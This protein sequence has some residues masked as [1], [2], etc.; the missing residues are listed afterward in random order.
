[1]SDAAVRGTKATGAEGAPATSWQSSLTVS[2]VIPAYTMKRWELL[3]KAVQSVREQSCPVD[4]IVVCIDNNEELL[5]NARRKWSGADEPSVMVVPND[6]SDHLNRATAHQA[7]HGTHRRFGAGSARN[8]ALQNVTSDVV[9]FIDDDAHADANWIEELLRVFTNPTIQA[10]GGPPLPD[11]QTVR[12]RWFPV[13]FDWVFGCAYAGLPTSV[14]PLG[15]L[16]GA[17]MAVRREALQAI[18][19]FVGSDFDDLNVCMRLAERYGAQSTYYTP[20]AIVHHFVTAERVTWRYFWRRCYFVNRE[21]V[22]V[23]KPMGSAANLKAERAF[24]LR[25]LTRQSASYLIRGAR[26]DAGAA[27]S[28]AAMGAGIGLA[29]LG[30]LRGQ[31]DRIARSFGNA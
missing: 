26:G 14:A 16:I 13:N 5:A 24:V 22:R 21:K 7:A 30:H 9:A 8:T 1:M 3:Q 29:A 2:V 10:V 18:G 17:N 4:R 6:S 31:V 11:Y 28:M 20:Y 19:G 25:A 15:H 12:P 27:L 23:F